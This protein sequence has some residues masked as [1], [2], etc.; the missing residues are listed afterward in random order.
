M[1]LTVKNVNDTFLD[2][3]YQETP[4]E[5][6]EDAIIVEGI[7]MKV[8]F[9]PKRVESNREN[10]KT[11]LLQL[12]DEFMKS[13]GGGW[14]FIKAYQTKENVHWGEHRNV[15]Q[16]MLIGLATDLVEYQLPREVWKEMPGGVPYFVV[17]DVVE[18][19]KG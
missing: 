4:T 5:V 11:M 7:I 10:I 15:E 6:P 13:G 16:L 2:C 19:E 14:S 12:P 18:T 3:L 8:G 17:N 1:E 9:D